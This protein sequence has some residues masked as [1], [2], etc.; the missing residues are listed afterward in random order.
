MREAY[1]FRECSGEDDGR[2]GA[3]LA[4]EMC[5]NELGEERQREALPARCRI[6]RLE[7]P[8]PSRMDRV[9]GVGYR[10]LGRPTGTPQRRRRTRTD[11]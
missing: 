10:L 1:G 2:L 6:E 9:Q 7:L 4:E 5:L 11:R 8:G 3:W